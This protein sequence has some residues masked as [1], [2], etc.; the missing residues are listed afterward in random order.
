MNDANSNHLY[1]S[2][3]NFNKNNN[4]FELTEYHKIDEYGVVWS[5]LTR[6]LVADHD[7]EEYLHVYLWAKHNLDCK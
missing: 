1:F 2:E 5:I 7:G 6:S 4:N 3:L